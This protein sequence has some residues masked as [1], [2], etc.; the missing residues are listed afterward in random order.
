[1]TP[2]RPS[3]D[4][5]IQWEI[6]APVSTALSKRASSSLSVSPVD[7]DAGGPGHEDPADAELELLAALRVRQG[8]ACLADLM[9]DA[10][11]PCETG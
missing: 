3:A 7:R 11:P 8:Y 10:I 1:M 5:H 2:H 4:A 9:A 6:L